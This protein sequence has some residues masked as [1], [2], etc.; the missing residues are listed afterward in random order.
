[1]PE[2]WATTKALETSLKLDVYNRV[3][4]TVPGTTNLNFKTFVS[5]YKS[6]YSDGSSPD[7]FGAAGSYDATYLISYAIA[8]QGDK[9]ITGASIAEG[10]SHVISG[11]PIKAGTTQLPQAFG[12]LG[13]GQNI[14]YDGAS[15]PL[16]FDLTN[17][18]APS[19]IQFWCVPKGATSGITSG[20]YY[21][22][23]KDSAEA[24][25][26]IAKNCAF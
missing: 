1:M 2:V 23:A 22:A 19:D 16:N 13:S 4:G 15:G 24:T 8:S 10:L 5:L 11:T 18:E 21:D 3:L 14:D 6:Q 26:S 25:D 17:G 20:S 7:V 9:P 12:I